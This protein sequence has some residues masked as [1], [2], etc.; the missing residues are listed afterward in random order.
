MPT[1]QVQWKYKSGLGGPWE[2]GEIVELEAGLAEHINV[3]SP[4]VLEPVE[5]LK[6]KVEGKEPKNKTGKGG[7]NRMVTR[8]QNRASVSGKPESD[9]REPFV[10]GRDKPG[11]GQE[12]LPDKEDE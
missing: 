1:Y 8:V 4:G 12:L 6:L 11:Y 7:K 3:D 5:S 10:M 2:K 9:L